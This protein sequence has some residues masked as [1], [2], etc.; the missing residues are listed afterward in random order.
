MFLTFGYFWGMVVN[1][2]KVAKWIH[3]GCPKMTSFKGLLCS[4]SQICVSSASVHLYLMIHNETQIKISI[5]HHLCI[6]YIQLLY[7]HSYIIFYIYIY[8]H[9]IK[10]MTSSHFTADY[11]SSRLTCHSSSMVFLK[12]T[13]YQWSARLCWWR[14]VENVSGRG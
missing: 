5:W 9:A 1:T 6:S 2:S 11:T 10:Y 3:C 13:C 14:C 12:C 7:M 8:T 4:H